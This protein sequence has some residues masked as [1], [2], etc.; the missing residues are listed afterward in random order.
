MLFILLAMSAHLFAS[1]KRF[2][3]H[4]LAAIPKNISDVLALLML[5]ENMIDT[6]QSLHS[7]KVPSVTMISLFSEIKSRH[8]DGIPNLDY[9]NLAKN[10]LAGFDMETV[11]HLKYLV[12]VDV[13]NNDV[14]NVNFGKKPVD[15]EIDFSGNPINYTC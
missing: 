3:G 8:F 5:D 15:F 10:L 11:L 4:N 12:Y 13:A 7:R 2:I 6:L 9:L 1:M 14:V